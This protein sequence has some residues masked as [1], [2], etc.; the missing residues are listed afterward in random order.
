MKKYAGTN[1]KAMP[2]L[3]TDVDVFPQ[4]WA[5]EEDAKSK[6]DKVGK[7]AAP[8][9]FPPLS[10]LITIGK[11]ETASQGGVDGKQGDKREKQAVQGPIQ[12]QKD[13]SGKEG[14][15]GIEAKERSGLGAVEFGCQLID[16][17]FNGRKF[18]PLTIANVEVISEE[19]D[20]KGENEKKSGKKPVKENFSD[21]DSLGGSSD[22][23]VFGKSAKEKK[24]GNKWSK[25]KGATAVADASALKL[26]T[27]SFLTRG[28]DG[29]IISQ[30]GGKPA[31]KLET[32][33][34]HFSRSRNMMKLS[35][36]ILPQDHLISSQQFENLNG[37]AWTQ[38]DKYLEK[39]KKAGMSIPVALATPAI[40]SAAVSKE[41]DGGES[42]LPRSYGFPAN[43]RT[44]V[45][46]AAARRFR[47]TFNKQMDLAVASE[48]F[49]NAEEFDIVVDV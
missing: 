44:P 18:V 4:N 8:T 27:P 21:I 37:K 36:D 23:E 9:P 31:P 5:H 16:T 11:R 42:Q 15:D 30:E 34:V 40:V 6:N 28:P 13:Q 1:P 46:S 33:Q 43:A 26:W 2:F 3:A 20:E 24:E 10:R 19:K 12:T 32:Y 22:D 41:L 35:Y 25:K 7:W 49:Q 17:F 45:A 39:R 48:Q 38:L 14:K 47:G 29:K